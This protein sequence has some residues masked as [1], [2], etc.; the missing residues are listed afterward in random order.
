MYRVHPSCQ[1][2]CVL[3]VITL[4]GSWGSGDVKSLEVAGISD[5]GLEIIMLN[6][7]SN[8]K[9]KSPHSP[10][11]QSYC[12][13]QY[14]RGCKSPW[15]FFVCIYQSTSLKSCLRSAHS[16]C[17]TILL[18]SSTPVSYPWVIMGLFCPITPKTE[19]CIKSKFMH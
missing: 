9:G 7:M 12:L 16:S 13:L 14:H 6:K 4:V 18:N 10:W 8:A 17:W 11:K 3:C 15:N 2:I 1:G 5:R 19:L